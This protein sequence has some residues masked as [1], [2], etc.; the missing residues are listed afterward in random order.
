MSSEQELIDA[1]TQLVDSKDSLIREQ[2]IAKYLSKHLDDALLLTPA[3]LAALGIGSVENVLEVQRILAE[4][5]GKLS[6]A[7]EADLRAGIAKDFPFKLW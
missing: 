2:L 7:A 4:H 3:F 6:E 1:I 5:P